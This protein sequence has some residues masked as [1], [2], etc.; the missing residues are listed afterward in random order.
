MQDILS[1]IPM[2]HSLDDV[3]LKNLSSHTMTR[4]FP[5]NTII[6][7]DGDKSDSLYI[8]QSGKIKVFLMDGS[9]KEVIL[10]FQGPGEYFGEM[11]LLDNEPRSAS[12]MTLETSRFAIISK[13]EFLACLRKYP[14]TALEI[15][16]N[17][18]QRLRKL[19]EDVRSLALM[20]VYGRVARTLLSMAEPRDGKLVVTERLTQQDLANLVGSSREM[21]T[22]IFKELITGGYI[23][24]NKKQITINEK[25][26]PAW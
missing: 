3:A 23:E 8:I 12:I 6:I 11:A 2:F 16:K 22:R 10:N 15:I 18:S 24:V 5:K 7:T 13:N 14:E 4:S 26:P 9:G 17:Q 19:T 20:D 25:L 21:V 1:T